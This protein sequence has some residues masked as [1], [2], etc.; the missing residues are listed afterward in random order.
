MKKQKIAT[1]LAV[2]TLAMSMPMTVSATG[3]ASGNTPKTTVETPADQSPLDRMPYGVNIETL[4]IAEAGKYDIAETGLEKYD[5]AELVP[6]KIYEVAIHMTNNSDRDIATPW[7]ID[8]EIVVPRIVK[9]KSS[10]C[11][12]VTASSDERNTD[13]LWRHS[14]TPSAK[15]RAKEDVALVYQDQ[16]NYVYRLKDGKPDAECPDKVSFSWGPDSRVLEEDSIL[17][18]ATDKALWAG[19]SKIVVFQF[20]TIALSEWEELSE[21]MRTDPVEVEIDDV[22]QSLV[23]G[24]VHIASTLS[25]PEWLRSQMK[26]KDGLW[27]IMAHPE[28]EERGCVDVVVRIE[29]HS[30]AYASVVSNEVR[31]RSGSATLSKFTDADFNGYHDFAQSY[32]SYEEVWVDCD[33]SDYDFRK[34]ESIKIDM[35]VSVYGN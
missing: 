11:I 1:I 8:Y 10:P 28:L 25:L 2:L 21:A 29:N 18:N 32:E 35:T 26:G 20:K 16:S 12:E 23:D 13:D 5:F 30:A 15:I 4:W 34:D 3:T 27:R 22:Y 9:A 19:S 17:L 7:G 33:T 24:K 14:W 31:L 6:G